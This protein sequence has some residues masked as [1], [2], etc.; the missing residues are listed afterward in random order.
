MLETNNQQQSRS[1][2]EEQLRRFLM[3]GKLEYAPNKMQMATVESMR[4]NSRVEMESLLEH[5]RLKEEAEGQKIL[6]TN[7]EEQQS[8][9]KISLG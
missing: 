4:K 9:N 8:L 1:I 2:T 5:Q 7:L 3:T 6:Q